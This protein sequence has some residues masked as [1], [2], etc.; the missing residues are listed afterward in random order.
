[1]MS[2]YQRFMVIGQAGSCNRKHRHGGLWLPV[3]RYTPRRDGLVQ[4]LRGERATYDDLA[5]R[6]FFSFCKTGSNPSR[7]WICDARP[8]AVNPV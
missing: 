3:M 7:V 2:A 6:L 5:E 1:M 4:K 8:L